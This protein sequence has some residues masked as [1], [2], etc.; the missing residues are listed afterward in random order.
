MEMLKISLAAARVNAEMTQEEVA[1]KMHISKT[2]LV[3]WEKGLTE[4][5]FASLNMLCNM[6]GIH[7]DN[8]FL[9][10]KHDLK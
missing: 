10:K 5:S 6:Y 8:I 4:P 7:V 1:Q 3:K 2:T 9:P